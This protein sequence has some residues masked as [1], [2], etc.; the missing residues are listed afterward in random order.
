MIEDEID[1]LDSVTRSKLKEISNQKSNFYDAKVNCSQHMHTKNQFFT[2]TGNSQK[3]ANKSNQNSVKTE[4]SFAES[5]LCEAKSRN[6]KK[7]R[8]L[9]FK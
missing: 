4:G 5:L 1:M 3:F 6:D 9:L 7:F 2:I 8:H